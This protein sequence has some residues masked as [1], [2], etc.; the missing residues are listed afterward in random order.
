MKRSIFLWG[1]IG[2]VLA[3]A[4]GAMFYGGNNR[5][6]ISGVSADLRPVDATDWTRGDAETARAE[7]IEYSDFECPG[8]AAYYPVVKLL[9]EEFAGEIVFAYRHFPLTSI[10][11][12]ATL[13]ARA[14]EAAG[15]QGKFWEMH[16]ELFSGQASWTGKPAREIFAGYA[17]ILGLNVERF[18]ADMDSAEAKEKVARGEAEAVALKLSGTPTFFLNGKK[19]PPV[20][21][22]E[23]FRDIVAA[24]LNTIA[25]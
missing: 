19:L 24:E 10:H 12:N 16:D 22:Y 4:V 8:C 9:E 5:V 6:D 18:L 7:L 2:L 1:G 23:E 25:Q 15:K 21:S 3:L 14:A 13:A 20:R 11:M 17:R